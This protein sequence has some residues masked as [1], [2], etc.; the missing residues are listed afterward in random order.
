MDFHRFPDGFKVRCITMKSPS[1]SDLLI[2]LSISP[3]IITL[4]QFFQNS[5]MHAELI[6]YI[7]EE[8]GEFM[9]PDWMG[10]GV[11]PNELW[12]ANKTLI[13]TY[14]NTH[15][16]AL[17]G[18]LWPEVEHAWGDAKTREELYTFLTGNLN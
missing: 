10:P 2:T 4:N 17:N 11:T 1:S 8:L 16:H 12:A 14:A 5:S 3:V 18:N 7:M 15:N 13:V 6:L 9:A